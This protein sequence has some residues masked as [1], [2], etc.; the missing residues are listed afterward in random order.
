MKLLYI[1][2]FTF[3]T[4]KSLLINKFINI[5]NLNIEKNKKI[6]NNDINYNL[7]WYVIGEKNSFKNNK[8]YKITIWDNDYLVWRNNTDYYAMDNY[9]S[10]KGASL[11]IGKLIRIII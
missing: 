7:N 3:P 2:F 6:E 9:C 5:N 1:F 8:P 4:I 11:A 10:H